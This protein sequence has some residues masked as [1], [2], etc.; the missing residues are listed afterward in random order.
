MVFESKEEYEEFAVDMM[1]IEHEMKEQNKYFDW[2][3]E[4]EKYYPNFK[5]YWENR[6]KKEQE[7]AERTA[8]EIIEKGEYG[9]DCGVVHLSAFDSNMLP[10]LPDEL[11]GG[12]L[13]KGRKMLLAG[14]SKAGKTGL[15]M[16]LAL[17][18]A[19][20][21]DW[22]GFPCRKC[23]VLYIDLENDPR[24]SI[25]RFFQINERLYERER[26]P[27][28]LGILN[29]RG[30]AKPL[31]EL[32]EEIIQVACQEYDAVILDP[33]YKII[34]GDENSATDMAYFCRQLDEIIKQTGATVIYCHHHSKGAQ[35]Q[36]KA[37]DRASGSGVFARDA[38]ALLDIIELNVTKKY[39][40]SYKVPEGAS[41]WRMEFT[42]REFAPHDPIDF[43]HDY[44]VHIVDEQMAELNVP[45]S[46]KENLS[47]SSKQA[48]PEEKTAR[49]RQVLAEAF[50][51]VD[52]DESGM[53]EIGKMAEAA[54]VSTRTIQRY[55]KLFPEEYI[56]PANSGMVIRPG[57]RAASDYGM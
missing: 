15:L 13:R 34:T 32:K 16:E 57:T 42:L 8:Q 23:R 10:K 44:P 53:A 35:G 5:E 56:H 38:D 7:D 45:G 33:M 1:I 52:P 4:A 14:P 6:K 2:N 46:R 28:E 18:L 20:G 3:R 37:M 51:A 47:A 31:D 48:D 27:Y 30:R 22:L 55:L 29:W 9:A 26:I 40:S 19:K 50:A 21:K 25:H 12:I 43:W 17:A 39:R 54:K 49:A 36:K 41:A 24:T 11:I